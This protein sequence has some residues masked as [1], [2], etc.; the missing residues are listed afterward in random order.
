MRTT[1]PPTLVAAL[2]GLLLLLLAG[3]AAA[4]GFASNCS[5]MSM[6]WDYNYVTFLVANCRDQDGTARSSFLSMDDCL[7]NIEGELQP[8]R[9]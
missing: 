4:Q 8:A 1:A 7:S 5:Q 2:A 6:G 3:P 9:Q